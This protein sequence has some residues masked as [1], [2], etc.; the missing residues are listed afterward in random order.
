[1]TVVELP[2]YKADGSKNGGLR[3]VCPEPSPDALKTL[4]GSATAEKADVA[5]LS[6]AFQESAA[7]IGLRTQSIQ[8]LRDQLF[9][10]CQAYANG[11]I[12]AS[13][14][15]MLLTRNQRNTV[16]IMAIEQLT[17]VVRGPNVALSGSSTANQAKEVMDLTAQIN[18][19]ETDYNKMDDEGKKS[20]EGIRMKASIDSL[21]KGLDA[22]RSALVST[23][24][25]ATTTVAPSTQLDPTS[26]TTVAEAVKYI[27]DKV[28]G[29]NDGYYLCLDA[30]KTYEVKNIPASLKESCDAIFKETNPQF[31]GSP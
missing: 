22:A 11:A 25:S 28:T 6:I 29:V 30:Y 19:S 10:I 24:G 12:N 7:N 4:A 26:L 3:V 20:P 8:L 23:A 18:T 1:M 13:A 5:A 31:V 14:Y 9:S 15:Q 2:T 21:K 16:A 17:G 27:S